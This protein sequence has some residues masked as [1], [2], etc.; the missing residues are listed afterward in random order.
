MLLTG[1]SMLWACLLKASKGYWLRASCCGSGRLPCFGAATARC[2]AE[3]GMTGF[4]ETPLLHCMFYAVHRDLSTGLTAGMRRS[5]HHFMCMCRLLHCVMLY[6]CA[7]CARCALMVRCAVCGASCGALTVCGASGISV[8]RN[9]IQL[10]N[11][12]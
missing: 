5:R 10:N 1:I 9:S 11:Q 8:D 3:T 7:R 2:L 6:V 12:P 4:P